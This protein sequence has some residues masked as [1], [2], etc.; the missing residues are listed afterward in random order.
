MGP[1]EAVEITGDAEHATWF[2]EVS[3]SC[4][5]GSV[6]ENFSAGPCEDGE[7]ALMG[8][9][10]GSVIW[11]FV[12]AATFVPPPGADSEY[13]YVVRFSGL[14]PVVAVESTTWGTVKAL[15]Q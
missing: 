6:V 2:F 8:H 11:F 9:Q 12:G 1:G 13:D 5:S 10:P 7:M 4:S 14:E 15:Y 3:P